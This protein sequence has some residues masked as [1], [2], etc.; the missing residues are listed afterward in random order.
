VLLVVAERPSDRVGAVARDA[1]SGRR[2]PIGYED[3]GCGPS[4]DGAQAPAVGEPSTS[5]V[6]QKRSCGRVWAPQGSTKGVLAVHAVL[7]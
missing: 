2:F 7:V 6:H 3:V 5:S 1:E 4:T